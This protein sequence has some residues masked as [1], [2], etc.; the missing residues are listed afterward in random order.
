M[1]TEWR[2]VSNKMENSD[3]EDKGEE[4]RKRGRPT[5]YERLSKGRSMST[6]KIDEIMRRKRERQ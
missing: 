3:R 4:G 2:E 6:E 5:N 1:R